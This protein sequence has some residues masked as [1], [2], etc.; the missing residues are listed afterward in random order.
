MAK[1][2]LLCVEI[3]IGSTLPDDL[4]HPKGGSKAQIS[5]KVEPEAL[6]I[7]ETYFAA[8][9]IENLFYFSSINF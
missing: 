4:H 7:M 6:P 8:D 1:Q 2:S 3:I 9:N 5:I